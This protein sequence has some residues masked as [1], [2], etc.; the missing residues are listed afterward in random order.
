[1]LTLH[2]TPGS[3]RARWERYREAWEG[4][5]GV[6]IQACVDPEYEDL[7]LLSGMEG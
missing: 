1:M 5:R 4:L 3:K 7:E 6:E 2:F